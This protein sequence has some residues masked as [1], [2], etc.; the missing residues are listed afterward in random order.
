MT[1]AVQPLSTSAV[2]MVVQSEAGFRK[3]TL[4]SRDEVPGLPC[5]VTILRSSFGQGME[6]EIIFAGEGGTLDLG[7]EATSFT[8]CLWENPLLQ[9]LMFPTLFWLCPPY[10]GALPPGPPAHQLLPWRCCWC[11]RRTME[12]GVGPRAG[13]SC[14]QCAQAA[15]NCNN[16]CRCGIWAWGWAV[17]GQL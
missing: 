6:S 12:F 9:P 3:F 11:R 14:M 5:M 8:P 7:E 17:F 4:I 1:E 10:P 2:T 16:C 13:G 15:G